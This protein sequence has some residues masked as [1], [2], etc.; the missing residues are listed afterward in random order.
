M[1]RRQVQTVTFLR[2][3][4]STGED[5]H[6]S[7]IPGADISRAS[8]GWLVAPAAGNESISDSGQQLIVAFTL[9]KRGATEDVTAFDRAN[10]RGHV[11]AISGEPGDWLPPEWS[12]VGGTV[13]NVERSA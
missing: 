11:Y 12:S 2:P 8:A 4:A 6:G 7:P 3:G 10:I 1:S 5:A 9:Y 13:I